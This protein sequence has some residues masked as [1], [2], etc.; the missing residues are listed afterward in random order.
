MWDYLKSTLVNYAFLTAHLFLSTSNFSEI[1]FLG[2]RDMKI[3][4]G[5]EL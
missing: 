4:A 5:T 2:N 1:F 3:K